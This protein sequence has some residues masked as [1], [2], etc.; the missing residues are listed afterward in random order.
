MARAVAFFS[1]TATV[2]V[3]FAQFEGWAENQI[4]ASICLWAQARGAV[5]RDKVYLD[6]GF[7]YWRQGL[8][9]G[10]YGAPEQQENPLGLMYYLNFSRPFR[11]SDNLTSLFGTISKAR[12]GTGNV[13]NDA[14]NYYDGAMLVNDA[15][16]S[17][18]GG[19][20]KKT[21]A[22]LPPRA[23]DALTYQVYQY[24]PVRD[25]F[26]PGFVANTLPSG[27]T[28]Y[29]AYG[30]A[31]SAPSENMA[32][33][34]GGLRA[35]HWGPIFQRNTNLTENAVNASNT[36]L[37]LD[38]ASQTDLLWKNV[39]L[40][41][42]V[43]GRAN[44]EVV[45]VPVGERGIL[46]V[47][48]G[49]T[50]PDWLTSTRKSENPGRSKAESDEFASTIDIFDIANNAW[51][52]QA[53]SGGPTARTRACAVVAPAQDQSSF[54]IYYYG[55]YPGVDPTVE[56]NDEVWIL[57][58]PSFTWTMLSAGRPG[59]GRNGH[60]CFMPYPDQMMVIG[61]M[62]SEAGT[63]LEC[64]TDLIRIYNLTSGQWMD[65]Y[66]PE[67]HA[68]YGVPAAVRAVIG[69]SAAGGATRTNPSPSGWSR[70]ELADVFATPY[71][72]SKIQTWYPYTRQTM[73]NQPTETAGDGGAEN[74]RD[75]L[76]GSRGVPHWVGPTLGAVLGF[77]CLSALLAGL[78]LWRRRK[79]RHP[80]TQPG[81]NGTRI[82]SW[83]RGQPTDDKAPTLTTIEEMPSNTDAVARFAAGA[84][85]VVAD[86]AV[87]SEMMD[88]TVAELPDTSSP[89]ELPDTGL[90]PMEIM[91]KHTH[92]GDPSS[93]TSIRPT[94]HCSSVSD[95]DRLSAS[96]SS[97][98]L[99]PY[100]PT[101]APARW[102][103]S[104]LDA[105]EP[106]VGMRDRVLSA[107]SAV[108]TV[109]SARE[110]DTAHLRQ[111]SEA[112]V[113]AASDAD[114]LV[115]V[116]LASLRDISV[117]GPAVPVSGLIRSSGLS[118]VQDDGKPSAVVQKAGPQTYAL[119]TTQ[120]TRTRPCRM[121]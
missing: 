104:P 52:R 111:T 103:V 116:A 13:N 10:Q 107:I 1:L 102:I 91:Y 106:V 45:W 81:Y 29:V 78:C 66:D 9:N 82:L 87:R 65:G 113:S 7:Q 88:T 14:P 35:P 96:Y 32:W 8:S 28:R 59:Y 24:G 60:N 67:R 6:G 22:F 4:N 36:L 50:Y 25:Q 48:G 93:T 72:M 40:P 117:A 12:G 46:V 5:I 92:F 105:S 54:N 41:D 98:V 119:W 62:T 86:S 112:T 3:V 39:T 31:V 11:S 56:M 34:V 99:S 77:V 79:L 95:D 44:P 47:I 42:G 70:T 20:V 55:G 43:K 49:V 51:Y 120:K 100:S 38:M 53:T 115:P 23:D 108:S 110:R 69:G 109:S 85:S 19:L 64:L 114:N 26:E 90:T 97:G 80:G 75:T 71:P 61:G 21:D 33:Y 58:L 16:L 15:Q 73:A 18:Y 17:L 89:L 27:M 68:E 30:G 2:G 37:T 118:S 84:P 57:S 63:S 121:T 76:Q 101:S 94:Y 83:I 74:G